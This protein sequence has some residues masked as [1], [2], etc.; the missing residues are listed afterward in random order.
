MGYHMKYGN[1]E[2]IHQGRHQIV[3]FLIYR[4]QMLSSSLH[5]AYLTLFGLRI[6]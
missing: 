3:L 4:L 5:L 1:I 2:P 6:K